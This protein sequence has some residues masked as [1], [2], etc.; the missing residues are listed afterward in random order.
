MKRRSLFALITA[1]LGVP[2]AAT[3]TVARR[4]DPNVC[5]VCLTKAEPYVRKTELEYYGND[6]CLRYESRDGMVVASCR[7]PSDTA[8]TGPIEREIR[9]KNCN[10]SF[11]QDAVA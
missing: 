3:A 6:A 5:P 4:G 11:F 10:N 2:A 1:S 7:I 9:C 8:L